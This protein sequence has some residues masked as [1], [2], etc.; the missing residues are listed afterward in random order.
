MVLNGMVWYH[1]IWWDMVTGQC[2]MQDLGLFASL[3]T[4]IVPKAR[5]L[6][7][8]FNQCSDMHHNLHGIN[9]QSTA[10][11]VLFIVSFKTPNV[12]KVVIDQFPKGVFLLKR[13]G[14]ILKKHLK[15]Q[16]FKTLLGGKLSFALH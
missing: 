2:S 11:M 8:F 7:P 4:F 6:L 16:P 12:L 10:N 9:A 14:I 15:K 1:V 3:A 5:W 13:T